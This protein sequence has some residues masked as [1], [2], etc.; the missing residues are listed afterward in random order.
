LLQSAMTYN[1]PNPLMWAYAASFWLEA[2]Q[3]A[4]Q[5]PLDDPTNKQVLSLWTAGEA[6]Q[7]TTRLAVAN[8]TLQAAATL[9][10][11]TVVAF[12]TAFNQSF[13]NS[14]SVPAVSDWPKY[15]GS[16]AT[17]YPQFYAASLAFDDACACMELLLSLAQAT[18]LASN[19]YTNG[20][21][22]TGV[23]GGSPTAAFSPSPGGLAQRIVP[24]A[25]VTSTATFT[26]NF[27]NSLSQGGSTTQPL[28]AYGQAAALLDWAVVAA[29][30]A[31]TSFY[32]ACSP[33]PVL[34]SPQSLPFIDTTLRRLAGY[35]LQT[36]VPLDYQTASAIT[37]PPQSKLSIPMSSSTA[38]SSRSVS[39]ASSTGGKKSHG[40]SSVSSRFSSSAS[41]ARHVTSS[42]S[43]K[44]KGKSN[45]KSNSRSSS[46][47]S[48]AT[49]ARHISSSCA[50]RQ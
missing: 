27:V 12:L 13:L 5:T 40:V 41:A 31:I 21:V 20:F 38:A 15:L 25:P 28:S 35:M 46:T 50:S 43:A 2:R 6:L 26:T 32:P 11:E 24:F 10:Q 29:D 19:G 23:A 48:A 3:A 45:S 4:L 39:S 18:G 47:G 36:Q 7:V 30:N 49:A 42:S 37:I 9:L 33:A 1:L 8:S 44:K 34:T 22:A 16:A 17:D 14:S